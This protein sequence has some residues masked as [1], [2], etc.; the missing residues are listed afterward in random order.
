TNVKSACVMDSVTFLYIYTSCLITSVDP[1]DSPTKTVNI[2]A[3]HNAW[4]A[5]V[6]CLTIF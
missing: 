6:E 2:E 3:G 4:K 5:P 1:G